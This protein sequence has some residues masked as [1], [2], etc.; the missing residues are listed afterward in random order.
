MI[1]LASYP[2]SGNTFFR[3]VLYEVYGI[4]SGDYHWAKNKELN[5]DF[6]QFPIVKTHLVPPQLPE[7]FQNSPAIYL[8]RDGRDSTVSE[9]HHRVDIKKTHPSY[10]RNLVNTIFGNGEMF[11]GGWSGHV[12]AW[13]SN[14]K[15]LI[16][17]EDLIDDPIGQV[18]RL[19]SIMDLPQPRIENLPT[20]ESQK[21]GIPKYGSGKDLSKTKQEQKEHASKFYRRGKIG[22]YKD[23]MPIYCQGLFWLLHRKVMKEHGYY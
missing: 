1:W 13:K 10:L 16:R 20:F 18:E 3:N 6:H 21:K 2:R 23:E 12:E 19:R 17:F 11:S 15:I 14:R 8:I 22:S 7:D 4:E 9:A 5:P